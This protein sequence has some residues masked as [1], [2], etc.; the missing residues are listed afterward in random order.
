MRNIVDRK[1]STEFDHLQRRLITAL[2]SQAPG[3]YFFSL[4]SLQNC[5]SVIFFFPYFGFENIVTDL[6]Q[7]I[8]DT[9]IETVM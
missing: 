6:I 4:I 5:F 7:R 1:L 9:I 8:V 3:Y 2:V